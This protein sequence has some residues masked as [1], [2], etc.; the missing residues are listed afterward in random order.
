MGI[1]RKIVFILAIVFTIGNTHAQVQVNIDLTKKSHTISPMIQGHGLIYCFE[2]DD[3]YADGS[4][5]QLYKDVGA[6]YLRYPG[7]AVTTMYHWNDLNGHG[8]T[9]RWNGTYDRA[10]DLAPENYMDL[11]EYMALCVAAEVE[12]MLGINM[13][14]GRN[15]NRQED[16]LNEAVA[17][18]KY[19]NEKKY[20][21]KYLYLDNENHHKKWTPEEY[22]NQ[23]VYYVD[24]IKKYAPEAKLI[25]N[26]TDKFRSNKGSFRTL[27]NIAGDHIDYMDVH[28][29][30][31][32]ENGT[33]AEWKAKTPMENE[34]EWYPNGGTFVEEIEYFNTMMDE[35]GKPHI[36]LASMEWNL[37][38]G[39]YKDDPNHNRFKTALMQ[40]EM[41]MQMMQGGLE[42]ASL[43]STQ[44][45]DDAESDFR[46][47]VSSSN[48]YMPTPT[49][50]FYELYKHA[51]N[52]EV[53]ASSTT[54]S[55]IMCTSVIKDNKAF[56][57]LLNK[58]NQELFV[59]I[60][61][62]GY[63]IQAAN[64]ALRFTDPGV[65]LSTDIELSDNR[66]KVLT[67]ENTLTMIEFQ[68]KDIGT[69]NKE[70]Q[71]KTNIRV[72]P[73][74]ASEKVTIETGRLRGEKK[75]EL[76][77]TLGVKVSSQT[78]FGEGNRSLTHSVEHL[79]GG[80]YFLVVSDEFGNSNNQKLMV[81]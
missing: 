54:H 73:N 30:W 59:N 25:G 36:K 18:L 56:V 66:Y 43:W 7:G 77:N 20:T 1:T 69:S 11:D 51:L 13:S 29:Y 40:S 4:M 44:W 74:P 55:Q 14:S 27:L 46:F 16:G 75:L 26:W 6:G 67:P 15:F 34:T 5:A 50:K 45:P 57:Y 81:E 47:L 49:A 35:L 68:L 37:G 76:Y 62:V 21:I 70:I 38:P 71:N 48:N 31:K 64:Q 10:N 78:Y 2:A 60:S 61:L 28:W 12:P 19:C 58:A 8:W 39:K 41:Q 52:G 23:I 65:L 32:W 9:D 79:P 17:L 3:I 33:W 42:I 53:V 63:E 72:Y 80:V 22:G 24:S